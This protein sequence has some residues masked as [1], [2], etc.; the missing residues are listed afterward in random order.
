MVGP[1]RV[2]VRELRVSLRRRLAR[3]RVFPVLLESEPEQLDDME[4]GLAVLVPRRFYGLNASDHRLRYSHSA[5]S[6]FVHGSA[7]VFGRRILFG[8]VLV[9]RRRIGLLGLG[10]PL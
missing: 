7:R 4:H 3:C 10:L 9:V 1:L 8:R 5:R 6:G 2:V